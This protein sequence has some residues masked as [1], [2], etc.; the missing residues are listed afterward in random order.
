MFIDNAYDIQ[1]LEDQYYENFDEYYV[2][3][4][5]FEFNTFYLAK[6]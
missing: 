5:F 3:D 1:L 6:Y 2:R 4:A